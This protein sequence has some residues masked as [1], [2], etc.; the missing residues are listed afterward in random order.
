MIMDITRIENFNRGW[1]AGDFE[2]SLIRTKDFEFAVKFYR[3]GDK[4]PRHVHKIAREIT[5]VISGKFKFN[6][7]EINQGDVILLSPGE[8]VD[9]EC[10]QDGAT[11]VIKMPS[12]I[13]DKYP[14]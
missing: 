6:G 11:A 1:L 3:A 7:R 12:V 4:E 14:V 2:P 13:G 9:F 10:L 8:A 5:A